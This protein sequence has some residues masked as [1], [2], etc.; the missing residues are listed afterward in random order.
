[1]A[2]F[3]LVGALRALDYFST[4]NMRRRSRDEILLTNNI[5]DNHP[6][7]AVIEAGGPQFR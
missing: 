7:F 2:L 6:A 1:V 5:V 4:L 3:A